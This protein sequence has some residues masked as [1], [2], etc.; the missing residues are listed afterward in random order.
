MLFFVVFVIFVGFVLQPSAV[1]VF[2]K[3]ECRAIWPR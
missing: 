3:D 2:E 1:S